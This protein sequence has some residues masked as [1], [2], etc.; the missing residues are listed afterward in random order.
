MKDPF[1]IMNK[2]LVLK[3]LF[4]PCLIIS[5]TAHP[6]SIDKKFSITRSVGMNYKL[7]LPPGYNTEITSRFPLILFLHGSGERGNDLNLVNKNGIPRLINE[8]KDFPFIIISPQCPASERSWD[9]KTLK[10]LLE[11]IIATCRVDTT[12]MYLTGLSMG[13]WGTWDMAFRYPGLFAA[14]APVYGFFDYILSDEFKFTPVWVFH[15]AKDDV[16]PVD[17]AISM[18][19]AVRKEGGEIRITLPMLHTVC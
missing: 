19:E 1:K 2:Q 7:Y 9:T 16:V 5:I 15:G 11:R 14:I 6:Q 17:R 13:G 12:R 3:A 18:F 8:G 4:L 10:L